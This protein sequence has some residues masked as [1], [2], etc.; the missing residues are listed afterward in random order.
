[1]YYNVIP[2]LT[3]TTG[4]AKLTQTALNALP[5]AVP[6]LEEQV[7]IVKR[8]SELF[9]LADQI[10]EKYNLAKEQVDKIT[11]SV[12]SKAFRGELVPQ[13]PNDEPAS[14]LLERI[15][16]EKEAASS[17]PKPKRKKKTQIES[18]PVQVLVEA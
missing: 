9:S 15:K 18:D 6:P 8:V 11:Q 1:M 7:V 14:I 12:L 13:D 10:E 17:K 5:I 3:G 4:R 2:W 16:S